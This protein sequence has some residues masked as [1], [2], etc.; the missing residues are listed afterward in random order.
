MKAKLPRW[1]QLSIISLNSKQQVKYKVVH[2]VTIMLSLRANNTVRSDVH[3]LSSIYLFS[4]LFCSFILCHLLSAALLRGWCREISRSQQCP[5]SFAG[6][7]MTLVFLHLGSTQTF[8]TLLQYTYFISSDSQFHILFIFLFS[9][10]IVKNCFSRHTWLNSYC[11]QYL[12]ITI[13]VYSPG[14]FG[15]CLLLYC[16]T[17][18]S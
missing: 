11:G 17:F 10:I 7:S 1:S 14:A 13:Y 15:I 6:K 16:A 2:S 12:T 4:Q 3:K 9:F 5:E 18:L 8:L